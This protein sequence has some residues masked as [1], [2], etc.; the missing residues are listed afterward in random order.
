MC[1]LAFETPGFPL[2]HIFQR[3]AQ[4]GRDYPIMLDNDSAFGAGQFKTTRVTRIDGS[5]GQ[6]ADG[7]I[8]EL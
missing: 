4:V 5:C 3:F 1:W 7:S 2:G 6:S 8:G